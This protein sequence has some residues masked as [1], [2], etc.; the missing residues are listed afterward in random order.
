MSKIVFSKSRKNLKKF[1][2]IKKKSTNSFEK[3]DLIIN[4]KII[5][6]NQFLNHICAKKIAKFRRFS[7]KQNFF[8][9][10]YASSSLIS[11][12]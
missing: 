3:N 9:E 8:L 10:M 5:F 11:Y 2:R 6:L 1:K 4:W 12:E 7:L